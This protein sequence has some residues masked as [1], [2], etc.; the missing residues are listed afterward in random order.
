MGGEEPYFLCWLKGWV[1]G[2][3]VRI[4][5]LKLWSTVV[6]VVEGG[7]RRSAVVDRV[8]AGADETRGGWVIEKPTV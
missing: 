7:A 8:V 4:I 3:C 2:L 6:I 5:E 1:D